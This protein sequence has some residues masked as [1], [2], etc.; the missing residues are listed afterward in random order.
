MA[1]SSP[2]TTSVPANRYRYIHNLYALDTIPA[3]RN[4]STKAAVEAAMKE[5]GLAHATFIDTSVKAH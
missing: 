5:H 1:R 2:A 3:G 4:R